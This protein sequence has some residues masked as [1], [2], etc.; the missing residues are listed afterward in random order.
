M[1][2]QELIVFDVTR[3]EWNALLVAFKRYDLEAGDETEF[4]NCWDAR[5]RKDWRED[6]VLYWSRDSWRDGFYH[7][8][9]ELRRATEDTCTIVL[10]RGD[11]PR[12]MLLT[13]TLEYVEPFL[14]K[15][16]GQP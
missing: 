2:R 11:D 13:K 9:L 10:V 1:E 12:S 5:S 15:H 3:N 8:K 7:A 6:E 16:K 14:R 4:D